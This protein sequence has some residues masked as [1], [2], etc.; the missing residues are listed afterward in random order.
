MIKNIY[1]KAHLSVLPPTTDGPSSV[2]ISG[3]NIVTAGKLYNFQCS[4]SCYPTCQLTWTWGN[5]TSQ[6]PELSLQLG[7]QQ[8][9]QI[10]T[11]T[12][13]NPTTGMSVTAQKTLQVT[14]NDNKAEFELIGFL[15]GNIT[16]NQI[17]FQTFQLD[18]QMFTSAVQPFLLQEL[19]PT[20]AVL[21]TATP[22]VATPGPLFRKIRH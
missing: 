21:L 12:A 19:R 3:V 2:A 20:L 13:V 6:G 5:A 22:P 1:I 17:Y 10:L 15:T 16:F 18:H 8:P 7:E 4:A 9:T 11:C 14:G